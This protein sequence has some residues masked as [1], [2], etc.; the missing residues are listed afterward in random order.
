MKYFSTRDLD[1]KQ[2]L[3]LQEAVIQGLADDGGLFMPEN[4][5]QIDPEIL[6]SF[7]SLKLPQIAAKML[8]PYVAESISKP[9]F[10]ALCQEVFNFPVSWVEIEENILS[11]ELFHALPLLLKTWAHDLWQGCWQVLPIKSI[12]M[13][14]WWQPPPATPEVPWLPAFMA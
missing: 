9:N 13:S 3:K 6:N 5:V 12:K 4:L 7:S 8:F 1:K 11:L 10:D 14:K 2:A